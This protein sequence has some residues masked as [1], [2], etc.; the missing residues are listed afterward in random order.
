MTLNLLDEDMKSQVN[1]VTG[2]F[3]VTSCK[4]TFA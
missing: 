3:P 2:I 1:D 4:E